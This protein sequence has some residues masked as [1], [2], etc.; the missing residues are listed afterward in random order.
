MRFKTNIFENIDWWLV[1]MYIALVFIGWISI[2][3]ALYNEGAELFD[4]SQKYGRQLIWIGVAGVIA[5]LILFFNNNFFDSFAYIIYFI[6]IL[7]LIA[8]LI[9]GIKVNGARSWFELGFFRFQPG[10][11]AK[12]ATCLAIAKFLSTLNVKIDDLKTKLIATGL[13]LLP[14]ILIVLQNDTGS[15]LVYGSF[16]IVLYRFG[17]PGNF[18]ILIIVGTILFITSIIISK[19]VLIIILIAIAILFFFISKRRVKEFFIITSALVLSIGFSSSV[20]Y[21][22]ENVLEPHQVK[23]ILILLGQESDPHGAGYNVNQSKIAIGSGGFTGK[24]FLNGTQT[25][26]NFVPE[27]STDFIFCTIGEEWGFI[28]STTIL[29]LYTVF[30]LRL[31]YVAE[32][33]RSLFSK[34]YGYGVV[35]IFFFHIGINVAMTIGLAP[36]IG[37]PLPFISYGGSSLWGFTIMLFIFINL[38]SNRLQVLR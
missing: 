19:I 34:I 17:L 10:E 29:L 16:I 3:A 5:T 12:F 22:F 24:G 20:D 37:I 31:I 7:L 30:L 2:Y 6:I 33:Q 25:K 8:V 4:F 21:V 1:L 26:F 32:R 28:G 23:R 13:I 27:Q 36:V 9:F 35:G 18:L 38:D 11:L 15:A 14:L